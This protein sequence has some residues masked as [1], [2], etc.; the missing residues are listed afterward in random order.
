MGSERMQRIANPRDHPNNR[1]A[2]R[3]HR[4]INAHNNFHRPRPRNHRPMPPMGPPPRRRSRHPPRH[5]PHPFRNPMKDQG[6][7]LLQQ[8]S[9]SHHFPLVAHLPSSRAPPPPPRRPEM[10][11]RPASLFFQQDEILHEPTKH[12]PVTIA[13]NDHPNPK[14][15]SPPPPGAPNQPHGYLSSSYKGWKPILK[16]TQD[17]YLRQSQLNEKE[18]FSRKPIF[19]FGLAP[20]GPPHDSASQ[21]SNAIN[22]NLNLNTL[23]RENTEHMKSGTEKEN[24][25][26]QSNSSPHQHDTRDL[27]PFPS[28]NFANSPWNN[29][30]F[31]NNIASQSEEAPLKKPFPKFQ[32]KPKVT[33][34][35]SSSPPSSSPG[36][37]ENSENH[38]PIKFPKLKF[39]R[40]KPRPQGKPPVGP[41]SEGDGQKSSGGPI[42]PPQSDEIQNS[43]P[44]QPPLNLKAKLSSRGRVRVR[45]KVIKQFNTQSAEEGLPSPK[46]L[47]PFDGPPPPPPP[48]Q[49]QPPRNRGPTFSNN[50]NQDR[51][52]APQQRHPVGHDRPHVEES[53]GEHNFFHKER[54][55]QSRNSSRGSQSYSHN[56]SESGDYGGPP[57]QNFFGRPNSGQHHNE[58]HPSSPNNGQHHNE[59]HPSSASEEESNGLFTKD[60][61]IRQGGGGT[62]GR[63]KRPKNGNPQSKQ[64]VEQ[65]EEP[66]PLNDG[67]TPG[68][69]GET[70]TN[71]FYFPP[72]FSADP[73]K[74]TGA[75]P[76]SFMTMPGSRP[77]IIHHTY[78]NSQHQ[79]Q[80]QQ[81][82]Q[83]L[84]PIN[85]IRSP[86][87]EPQFHSGSPNRPQNYVRH[88][89]PRYTIQQPNI[90]VTGQHQQQDRRPQEIGQFQNQ[91]FRNQHTPTAAF[92]SNHESTYSTPNHFGTNMVPYNFGA[93]YSPQP[94]HHHPHHNNP[95]H[96]SPHQINYNPSVLSSHSPEVQHFPQQQQLTSSSH[97]RASPIPSST[98]RNPYFHQGPTRDKAP[99]SYLV[100]Y[101]MSPSVN[102]YE[103][104]DSSETNPYLPSS[105][106]YIPPSGPTGTGPTSPSLPNT[107]PRTDSEYDPSTV[108][109]RNKGPVTGPTAQSV[110]EYTP[111]F[112]SAEYDKI[113]MQFADQLRPILQDHGRQEAPPHPGLSHD[114]RNVHQSPEIHPPANFFD[115][116]FKPFGDNYIDNP[117]QELDSKPSRI[118]NN[119]MR[120]PQS[121]N[122]NR[123][124]NNLETY[125]GAQSNQHAQVL[126]HPHSKS[127]AR[128]PSQSVDQTSTSHS[129]S[130]AHDTTDASVQPVPSTTT[131]RDHEDINPYPHQTWSKLKKDDIGVSSTETVPQASTTTYR[132]HSNPNSHVNQGTQVAHQQQQHHSHVVMSNSKS[133]LKAQG[134]VPFDGGDHTVDHAEEVT[135]YKSSFPHSHDI[136]KEVTEHVKSNSLDHHVQNTRPN[137][138]LSEDDSV[139]SN[140]PRSI[141]HHDEKSEHKSNPKESM[142]DASATGEYKNRRP[143]RRRRP[144]ATI[145]RRFFSSRM[146]STT[147]SGSNSDKDAT[148]TDKP[149]EKHEEHKVSGATADEE[150]HPFES[151]RG[152]VLRRR[153]LF[154]QRRNFN[155]A[156]PN[157]LRG[158]ERKVAISGGGVNGVS[159]SSTSTTQKSSDS[160]SVTYGES[161]WFRIKPTD[162]ME[163]S[164]FH[165]RTNEPTQSHSLKAGTESELIK[166]RHSSRVSDVELL[167]LESTTEVLSA[168]EI[169]KPSYS[170]KHSV[171]FKE[172][173]KLS[174]A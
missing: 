76:V 128:R 150:S 111:G 91:G 114:E 167:P 45:T 119:Q 101:V 173:R 141:T 55:Q 40:P 56:P 43:S 46:P 154:H 27:A 160:E 172:S 121:Y 159:G 124:K 99:Q 126:P 117:E 38:G 142:D 19:P 69:G 161:Q 85:V 53:E 102:S 34:G 35:D 59:V 138:S 82:Q 146:K 31:E 65:V 42:Y 18:G 50:P 87:S 1:P 8:M 14:L 158:P 29:N 98:A 15:V 163:S 151:Q 97:V 166:S 127:Y 36:G 66:V 22:K 118:V 113:P 135:T 92:P 137:P 149:E 168:E 162:S 3:H 26:F 78:D 81:Q 171:S 139:D 72:G 153:K 83:Q 25:Q 95:Y 110:S 58:V 73:S 109:P 51:P 148:T 143:L 71:D 94:P 100:P 9:G 104:R 169:Q 52:P 140:T 77:Q 80:T 48:T 108:F 165:S 44:N 2:M 164:T 133:K 106:P 84:Y 136:E 147:D 174:S 17:T 39:N 47:Q 68:P 37:S 155:G 144:E 112:G 63:R 116:F 86:S 122:A 170:S 107:S 6:A 60:G 33:S 105:T 32:L 49:S 157:R 74:T 12:V 131:A 62:G 132:K 16:P 20:P 96:N 21:P 67:P 13:A 89:R 145:R 54:P 90:G 28:S 11:E 93:A 156:G 152:P 61:G 5:P 125:K 64:V 10:Y 115:D 23:F 41:G 88:D 130:S 75:H 57:N 4:H 24:L 103:V 123:N 30:H 7:M 129:K 70:F 120:P 79:G 134:Q